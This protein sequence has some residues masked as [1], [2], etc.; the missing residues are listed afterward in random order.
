MQI[1]ESK[2]KDNGGF[3]PLSN[4]Q[5]SIGDYL[6]KNLV[7][8]EVQTTEDNKPFLNFVLNNKNFDK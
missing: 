6:E 1:I 3:N 7:S 5:E 4:L 8:K 2:D